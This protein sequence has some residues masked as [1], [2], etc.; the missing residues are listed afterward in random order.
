M[1]VTFILLVFL[2]II[3]SSH[4]RRKR[5]LAQ[6]VSDGD[7]DNDTSKEEVTGKETPSSEIPSSYFS[8]ETVAQQ[9][10]PTP[11]YYAPKPAV[12]KQADADETP[13]VKFDLRQ[14]VISQMILNNPYNRE[15]N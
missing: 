7:M 2:A 15:V 14:A 4:S 5:V 11:R 10:T 1:S 8:Y 12:A 13:S 9:S 3:M 6:M